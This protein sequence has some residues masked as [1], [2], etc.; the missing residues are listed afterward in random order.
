MEYQLVN[1]ILHGQRLT[2][3][4]TWLFIAACV[5]AVVAGWKVGCLLDAYQQRGTE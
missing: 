4:L 5:A 1:A 3:P 2:E